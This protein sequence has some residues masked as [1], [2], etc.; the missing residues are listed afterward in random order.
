MANL[1][2]YGNTLVTADEFYERLVLGDLERI[3]SEPDRQDSILFRNGNVSGQEILN[4][5]MEIIPEFSPIDIGRPLSLEF[6]SLYTGDAPRKRFLGGKPDLLVSTAMKAPQSYD[7]APRAINQIVKDIDDNR[8]YKPAALNEGSPIIYYTRAAEAATMFYTVELVAESFNR[9][10]FDFLG[11]LFQRAASIPIFSFA[12]TYL[13]A[14][15]NVVNVAGDLG[16][17]L[18]ESKPFLRSDQDIRFDTPGVRKAMSRLQVVVNDHDVWRFDGYMVG[19]VTNPFGDDKVTLVEKRTGLE[20]M[21]PAPYAII[22]ID[23]RERRELDEFAPRMATAAV[24]E[25]FF[26]EEIDSPVIDALDQAMRLY[27]DFQYRRKAIRLNKTLKGL[28]P[29]D[30]GYGDLKQL[31]DAYLKNIENGFLKSGIDVADPEEGGNNQ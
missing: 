19:R 31:L 1:F 22:S 11:S 26:G 30:P 29:D 17:H 21:G 5:N 14:G 25:K 7:V 13:L 10:I 27:N 23:G 12:K 16:K 3:A 9:D 24:M 18:F 28:S 2:V 20:Y 6:L 4:K 15:A 8:F